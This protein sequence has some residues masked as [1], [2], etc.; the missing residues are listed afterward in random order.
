MG[1]VKAFMDLEDPKK[2]VD[3]QY[4][5]CAQKEIIPAE[6]DVERMGAAFENF[7]VKRG[8][9]SARV[10]HPDLRKGDFDV[11]ETDV[12][13][14]DEKESGSI[15]LDLNYSRDGK[16]SRGNT[17]VTKMSHNVTV[18]LVKR[19]ANTR[20]VGMHMICKATQK[21]VLQDTWSSPANTK[22]RCS[23]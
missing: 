6:E 10:A 1:R 16:T 15:E 7:A 14:V 13:V 17:K 5:G 20:Y 19:Y 12:K 9:P 4:L 21:V 3:N 22:V 18:V 11:S 2:M 23:L 8:D